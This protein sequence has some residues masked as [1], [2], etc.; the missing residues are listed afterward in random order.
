MLL[1]CFD[2]CRNPQ[3]VGKPWPRTMPLFRLSAVCA[4]VSLTVGCTAPVESS[5]TAETNLIH[6]GPL[7]LDL[8]CANASLRFDGAEVELTVKTRNAKTDRNELNST[9][10]FLR[11]HGFVTRQPRRL[12][13]GGYTFFLGNHNGP[14][15][16]VTRG[17]NLESSAKDDESWEDIAPIYQFTFDEHCGVSW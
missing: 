14:P 13:E 6:Y 16:A 10:E 2:P 4:F 8:T 11:I 12:A 3:H 15:S 17:G 9:A 5:S 7:V 1:P